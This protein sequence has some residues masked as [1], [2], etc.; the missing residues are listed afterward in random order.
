VWVRVTRLNGAEV[1]IPYG[2][3]GESDATGHAEIASPP[4]SVQLEAASEKG[5]GH[6]LVTAS[7]GQMAEA[8][9]RLTEPIDH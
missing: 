4:G 5:K 7:V 3:R 9:V 2:G 6:V 1:S 8:E